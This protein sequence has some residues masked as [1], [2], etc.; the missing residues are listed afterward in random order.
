MEKYG[1]TCNIRPYQYN[2]NNN[3]RAI[4]DREGLESD[5]EEVEDLW[6]VEHIEEIL[7]TIYKRKKRGLRSGT[8]G[9]T[10]VQITVSVEPTTPCVTNTYERTPTSKQP[11]FSG[12]RETF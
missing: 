5:E 9:R 8:E 1:N 11:N 2:M 10:L 12:R 6:D 4:A 3:K 7:R